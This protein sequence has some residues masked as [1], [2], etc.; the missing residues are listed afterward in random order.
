M[1][2]YSWP[3]SLVHQYGRKETSDVRASS[4]CPIAA[5]I[6]TGLRSL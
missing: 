2:T 5:E 6:A 4:A 3:P 1:G